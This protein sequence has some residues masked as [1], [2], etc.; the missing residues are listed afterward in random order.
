LVTRSLPLFSTEQTN[1]ILS[2]ILSNFSL[3]LKRDQQD[4][5]IR[6]FIESF[7]QPI[8]TNTLAQTVELGLK[9]CNHG[10]EGPLR[11]SPSHQKS[12]Y[13]VALQNMAG[14]T[15]VFNLIERAEEMYRDEITVD[16]ILNSKWT[17]VVL[18][19]VDV[20]CG[21]PESSLVKPK[22]VPPQLMP[23]FQRF[24]IEQSKLDVLKTKLAQLNE[25]NG[26][27]GITK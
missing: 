5:V 21:L 19:I 8:A 9:L 13:S 26:E 14:A 3:V 27:D 6:Q 10:E 23:H 22:T 17:H 11:G 18:H 12:H 16:P 2:C 4:K 15:I 25:K 7:S 1:Y 20:I 24:P